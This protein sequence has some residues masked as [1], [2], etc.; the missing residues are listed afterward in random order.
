MQN[1]SLVLNIS[2]SAITIIFCIVVQLLNL[3]LYST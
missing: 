1:S 3:I 2:L